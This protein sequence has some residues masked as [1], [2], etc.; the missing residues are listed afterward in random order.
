ML[1][2]VYMLLLS[3]ILSV[4]FAH[5]YREQGQRVRYALKLWGLFAGI[6]FVVALVMF[7]FS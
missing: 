4:F 6:G 3:V 1:H 5:L 2:F 7:P